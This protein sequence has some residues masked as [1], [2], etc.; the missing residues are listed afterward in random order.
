MDTDKLSSCIFEA[1]RLLENKEYRAAFISLS[2][3]ADITGDDSIRQDVRRLRSRYFYLLRFLADNAGDVTGDIAAI[4]AAA[5][6][7][8]ERLKTAVHLSYNN[9]I[10]AELR[11]ESLRPEDNFSS[12]VS[13]YL[14]EAERLQTDPEALR[15]LRSRTLLD[16]LSTDIFNRLAAASPDNDTNLAE[17]ILFDSTILLSHR[18]MWTYALA[19]AV[20]ECHSYRHIGLLMK[21]G[22]YKELQHTAQSLLALLLLGHFLPADYNAA[23]R[24][25]FADRPGVLYNIMTTLVE[26]R[27]DISADA[28]KMS[29]GINI[30]SIDDLS[31][32]A[33]NPAMGELQKVFESMLA[34]ADVLFDSLGQQ[35]SHP[36]FGTVANWFMPFDAGHSA[37]WEVF[38]GEGALIGESIA[39]SPFM[40]DG[41]KYATVLSLTML[42]QQNRAR[43]LSAMVDQ[44]LSLMQSYDYQSAMEHI[45][46]HTDSPAAAL[47]TIR[48]FCMVYPQAGNSPRLQ[49]ASLLGDEGQF[50][51]FEL[52]NLSDEETYR[53]GIKAG[54]YGLPNDAADI[55]GYS[56][57]QYIDAEDLTQIGELYRENEDSEIEEFNNAVRVY[58]LALLALGEYAEAEKYF[59]YYQ[60]ENPDDTDTIVSAARQYASA[61]Y[62]DHAMPMI[63]AALDTAPEN[64][65]LLELYV[66]TLIKDGD[67]DDALPS[68]EKLNFLSDTPETRLLLLKARFAAGDFDGVIDLFPNIAESTSEADAAYAL[69]LWFG[70]LHRRAIDF[71]GVRRL[72]SGIIQSTA[73]TLTGQSGD[74][75]KL[76]LSAQCMA[77][78]IDYDKDTDIEN[79]F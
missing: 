17:S 11:F 24:K 2:D 31:K 66:S 78:I 43:A 79:T 25:Y 57:A 52:L 20:T 13:D 9:F 47:K 44:Q 37:L 18:R 61:G 70:G 46:Q 76:L 59:I 68:A 54:E 74:I 48:R 12:V 3:A 27:H 34:G 42:P 26:M 23:L 32:I 30:G 15:T 69:S 50:K 67:S 64:T 39:N 4:H 58:G 21:A 19:F 5:N 29:S 28:M 35:R 53:L 10:G 33:D 7:I 56:L 49:F 71:A 41:D 1:S 77:D 16:R 55:L 75:D 65:D 38:D 36:F 22:D 40:A 51:N 72:S 73:M 63:L 62:I 45:G 14:S 60:Q 6:G 8:V